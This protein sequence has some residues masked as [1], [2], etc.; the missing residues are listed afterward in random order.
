ME[1][2]KTPEEFPLSFRYADKVDGKTDLVNKVRDLPHELDLH[3]VRHRDKD[4]YQLS[5]GNI[6]FAEYEAPVF[7]DVAQ[8]SRPSPIIIFPLDVEAKRISL[9]S[10]TVFTLSSV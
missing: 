3:S 7:A 8:G 1:L 2:D 6:D 5:I 9:R 10:A 4:L